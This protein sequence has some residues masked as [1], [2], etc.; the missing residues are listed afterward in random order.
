MTITQNGAMVRLTFAAP[1][2]FV[3]VVSDDGFSATTQY[4]F[5]GC[6]EEVALDAHKAAGGST[7]ILS[8]TEQVN[9]RVCDKPIIPCS[10][11]YE[12]TA[13]RSP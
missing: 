1:S 10:V 4:Q 3:G 12:G 8:V 7:D 6:T 2:E 13:T 5:Q 9:V 11:V